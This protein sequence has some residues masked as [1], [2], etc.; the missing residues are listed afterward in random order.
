MKIPRLIPPI[1][2]LA[3]SVASADV[4]DAIHPDF[5]LCEVKMP[6]RYKTMGLAFLTDGTLVLATTEMV[7]GG[8]VPE[9][10]PGHQ[11]FLVRGIC[12]P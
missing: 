5:E 2:G 3:L 12:Q 1:L 10:D 11:V 6:A 7:G 4:P 9:A 8:E